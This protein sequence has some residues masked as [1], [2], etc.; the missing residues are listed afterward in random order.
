M[1]LGIIQGNPLDYLYKIK[2][3]LHYYMLMY[4]MISDIIYSALK[5]ATVSNNQEDTRTNK[6]QRI[7]DH[8]QC[9]RHGTI[10]ISLL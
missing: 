10:V 9:N 5:F 6:Q 1:I 7:L 4:S 3:W 2:S 8:N